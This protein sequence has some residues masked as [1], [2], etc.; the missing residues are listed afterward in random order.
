MKS[1][2][3]LWDVACPESR[4]ARGMGPHLASLKGEEQHTNPW[5]SPYPPPIEGA[6]HAQPKPIQEFINKLEI[7]IFQSLNYLRLIPY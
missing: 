6:L 4:Q 2:W 5:A 1:R 3:V 7:L